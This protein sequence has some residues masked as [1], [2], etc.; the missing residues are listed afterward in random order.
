M[1]NAKVIPAPRPDA[2]AQALLAGSIVFAM[3]SVS[4]L[5]FV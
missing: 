1:R 4:L 5:A 3:L 2:W